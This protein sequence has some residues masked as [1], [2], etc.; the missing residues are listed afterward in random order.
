MVYG[1]YAVP[2]FLSFI[3]PY[4]YIH[5]HNKQCNILCI[6]D[7]FDIYIDFMKEDCHLKIN[8]A[9]E[10]CFKLITV[11]FNFTEVRNHIVCSLTSEPWYIVGTVQHSMSVISATAGTYVATVAYSNRVIVIWGIKEFSVIYTCT[12]I[13]IYIYIYTQSVCLCLCIHMFIICNSY[14]IV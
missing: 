5:V 12:Y 10:I 9:Y 3:L 6:T 2:S 14:Y 4:N 13:Y 1:K 7:N 8:C 11:S